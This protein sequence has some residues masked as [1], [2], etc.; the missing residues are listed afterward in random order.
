MR[1]LVTLFFC[2]NLLLGLTTF[3][4]RFSA[5]PASDAPDVTFM[6]SSDK[7]EAYDFVEVAVTLPNPCNQD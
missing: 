1:Y 3:L 7:V 2:G 6:Q 4:L 5:G